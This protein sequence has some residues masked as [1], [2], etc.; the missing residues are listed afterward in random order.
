MIDQIWTRHSGLAA[1]CF[2]VMGGAIYMVMTGV[3]LAQIAAI[4]GQVPFDMRP[5]G[6]TP[7]DAAAL[8]EGLGVEGRNYYLSYQIPLDTAYPALLALTLICLMR[9]VGQNMCSPRLVRVGMHLSV[10]AAFC[11]YT[12][13]LGIVMMVLGWPDLPDLLVHASSFATVAKSILTTAAVA[14]ALV[15]GLMGARHRARSACQT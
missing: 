6:Y 8:L 4:S 3:T 10:A 12:E 11:D 13:N 2:G 7:Q 5:L 1:V 15:I 9:W 14:M